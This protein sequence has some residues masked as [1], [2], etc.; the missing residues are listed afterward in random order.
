MRPVLGFDTGAPLASLG[1][2]VRGRI[3]ASQARPAVSHGSALPAAVSELLDEAGLSLADVGGIAVGLGPGSFTG[4]RVG[5]SY[6]K[7]IAMAAGCAIMGVSTLDSIALGALEGVHA[8]PRPG[9][10]VCP[11]MDARKGEVYAALYR[12]VADGLQKLSDDLVMPLARLGSL[13]TA[14]VLLAG[15]SKADEAANQLKGK[16]IEVTI[17]DR[18]T[19]DTRGRLIAMMGAARLARRDTDRAET[20]EPLYVRPPDTGLPAA[21]SQEGVWSAERKNSFGSI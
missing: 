9:T 6:A 13:L 12:I 17:S 14:S 10:L 8:A 4:L 11:V 5:L 18:A 15:D 2:F 3:V 7:G 1:L 16:G 21:A 20:L 19:L